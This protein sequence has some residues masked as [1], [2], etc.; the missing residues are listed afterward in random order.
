MGDSFCCLPWQCSSKCCS[1]CLA[2]TLLTGFTIAWQS[3]EDTFA[4]CIALPRIILLGILLARVT[5]PTRAPP[6]PTRSLSSVGPPP[7]SCPD[8]TPSNP[9]PGPFPHRVVLTP[10]PPDVWCMQVGQAV[11]GL[12]KALPQAR[13]VYC[14]ATGASEPRNLGYMD[15]L[16]LWGPGTPSF[17]NFQVCPSPVFYPLPSH[18]ATQPPVCARHGRWTA[19]VLDLQLFPFTIIHASC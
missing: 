17:S 18:L 6:S 13:V 2:A 10:D 14:S 7:L 1:L 8:C 9:R 3:S 19:F 4:E 11:M 12:Q 15:R 16:G 5:S